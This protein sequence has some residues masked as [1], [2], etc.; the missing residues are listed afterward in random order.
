LTQKKLE[1][2]RERQKKQDAERLESMKKHTAS[3]YNKTGSQAQS[4]RVLL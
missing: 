3:Y 2:R 1:E 4:T